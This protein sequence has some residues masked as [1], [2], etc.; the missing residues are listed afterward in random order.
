[1][2]AVAGIVVNKLAFRGEQS[3]FI[4]EMPLYHVP[5]VR[6][7]GLYVWHNTVAFVK[8]AGTLIVIVVGHRLGALDASRAGI[9]HE[10][11]GGHRPGCWS[12]SGR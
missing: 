9:E 6:T 8:K 2:L 10:R 1:M 12:R 4:M 7:I 5:N 3:A 11:P